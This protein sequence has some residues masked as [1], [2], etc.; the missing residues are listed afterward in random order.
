[1]LK[2][3]EYINKNGIDSVEKAFKLKVKDYGDKVLIKYNQIESDM[4]LTEVQECRGL[5]L[6]KGTWKVMSLSFKKFFNNAE[7]LASK[8]D[9]DTAHVLEKLDGSMIQL[10]WDW[11]K[12][13]WFAATTGTAEGDGEVN[14]KFGTTFND[15]FWETANKINMNLDSLTKGVV[16]MFELTTPYNIVVKPHKE[17]SITLLA[18]RRLSGLLEI[19][20]N[21]LKD[22][23]KDLNVPLVKSYSMNAKNAGV[24]VN[25][26]KDMPWYDEGYVVVDANFNRVKL[27]NPEYIAVHHLKSKTSEHSIM[28]VVKSNEID[29]FVVAF[30]ERKEE[31]SRLKVNYDKLTLDLISVWE[32]LT[33]FKP[34]N[35]SKGEQKK[36]AMKVFEITSKRDVKEFSSLFFNLKDGKVDTV[37]NYM[38]NLDNKRLY[39]IL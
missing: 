4:S 2:I 34:K 15:L 6:E 20:Y 3:V 13:T 25:T 35:I 1:M 19:D 5:I 24:L 9:W 39:N 26:F 21:S 10:Y 28:E 27:K 36:F 12:E 16:Y 18:A 14:N 37:E 23:A 32:E 33:I 31:I 30:P 17:S 8:V 38:I 29:E 7:S 22:V 11:N